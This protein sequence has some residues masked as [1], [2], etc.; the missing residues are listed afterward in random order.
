MKVRKV[1]LGMA[2]L[3][4]L[5]FGL[6]GGAALAGDYDAVHF[7]N[8]TPTTEEVIVGLQAEPRTRGIQL[9]SEKK[10]AISM[11]VRFEFD[12]AELTAEA[13]RQLEPLG[14]ALRAPALEGQAFVVEGHT[15]AIGSEEY[16]QELSERRAQSVKQY[17]VGTYSVDPVRLRTVGKGER[18]LLN[19]GTPQASENRRVQIVTQ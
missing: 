16:N 11:G 18:E 4:A 5:M 14:E 17:L 19:A 6:S 7:G 12:S 13:K 2:G 8:R 15:D 1:K 3:A 10:K 9:H